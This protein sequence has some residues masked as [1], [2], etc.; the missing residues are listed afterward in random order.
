MRN[1]KRYYITALKFRIKLSWPMLETFNSM[2]QVIHRL[3]LEEADISIP[4]RKKN[5]SIISSCENE[6]P[7]VNG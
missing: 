7:V 6:H 5:C 4:H 1:D 2:E 3:V